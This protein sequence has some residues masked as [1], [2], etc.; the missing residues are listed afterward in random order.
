MMIFK[1]ILV[2]AIVLL[3]FGVLIGCLMNSDDDV[4]YRWREVQNNFYYYT[5]SSKFIDSY[6]LET[7]AF[8]QSP[9]VHRYEGYTPLSDSLNALA[10]TDSTA[11]LVNVNF[12]VDNVRY[13]RTTYIIGLTICTAKQCWNFNNCVFLEVYCNELDCSD[14]STVVL[15][16]KKD[17]HTE[18]Y[19]P[20]YLEVKK[21]AHELIPNDGESFNYRTEMKVY[22]HYRFVLNSS[23][24]K[25]DFEAQNS[26]LHVWDDPW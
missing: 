5:L 10:T 15:K 22:G 2:S 9:S 26:D 1:N 6:I 13:G 7:D 4:H 25:L 20:E 24:M 12:R 21:P 16:A 17:N 11:P 14:L 23:E 3:S 18:I 19:G 8:D